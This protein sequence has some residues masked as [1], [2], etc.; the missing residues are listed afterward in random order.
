ME[1]T[2]LGLVNL[3]SATLYG[4]NDIIV[5]GLPILE[6]FNI[7][8]DKGIVRVAD[9]ERKMIADVYLRMK[10]ETP[11]FWCELDDSTKCKHVKYVLQLPEIR[12]KLE[13]MGWEVAEK[14]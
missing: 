4:S 5:F 6:H 9:R 11:I 14:E 12:K 7:D 1:G 2:F 3:K 8:L 13:E 10:N